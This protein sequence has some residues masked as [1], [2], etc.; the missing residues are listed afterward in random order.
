MDDPGFCQMS[1]SMRVRCVWRPMQFNWKQIGVAYL[2]GRGL[3]RGELVLA[4]RL[5]I[6]D[7]HFTLHSSR[8]GSLEAADA[9]DGRTL[10]S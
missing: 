10:A 1:E 3:K 7:I 6:T 4:C 2:H 9:A 8:A 5:G